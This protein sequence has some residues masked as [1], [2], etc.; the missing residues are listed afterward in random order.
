MS[1]NEF[2][3]IEHFFKNLTH[4]RSDV[5]LG[6][7]DDCAILDPAFDLNLA[8]TTD[9]LIPNVHFP[10]HTLP[11]DIGYKSL[12]VNLSDLAAMGAE[13]SWFTLALTLPDLDI[14]WLEKF[15]E[16]LS[17]LASPHKLQLI[18]GDLT[19]GTLS[20]SITAFGYVKKNLF[21]KRSTANIGD[22]IYVTHTIGDAAA[23]LFILKNNI[24]C[25][26]SLK[27]HF[28]KALNRPQPQIDLGLKLA[29]I[30]SSAIDISDGLAADLT[31]ILEG[32][33]V[34]AEI[35]VDQL[36]LSTELCKTFTKE[37][38]VKF[39]LTGGDDYELCFTISPDKKEMME[40]F[41]VTCIGKIVPTKGLVLFDQNGN[42]Y[43]K[44]TGGYRHF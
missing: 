16:G 12:A 34:G 28:L 29:T 10:T 31:H 17:D 41:P 44:S 3:L 5:L 15:C 1:L 33:N 14:P 23:G 42:L 20:I 36:P 30:A 9:T 32:S 35:C 40:N 7:G 4:A 21:L 2:K 38:A 13:P 26:D 27:S 39:A 25:N 18:G 37:E 22:L 11:Y 43:Q 6:I 24:Q 8:V 19:R